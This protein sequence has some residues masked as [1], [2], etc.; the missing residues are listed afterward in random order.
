ML[1]PINF[2]S[3]FLKSSNQKELDKISKIVT[4]INI[5]EETVKNL[6]DLD[7]P[8]K[9]LDFKRKIK[10]GQSLDD[11]LPELLH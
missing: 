11:I 1:N 3:K 10:N 9:T 5:L 4:K 8:K 7:F 6:D 2:I